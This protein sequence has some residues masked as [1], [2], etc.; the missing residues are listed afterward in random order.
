LTS[1]WQSHYLETLG[2]IPAPIAAMF[3]AD[4]DFGAA[5]TGLRESI[6]AERTEGLDVATKELLFVVLDVALDNLPG[7]QNHLNAAV[8]AGLTD[9]AL[10][11]ALMIVFAMCGIGAW[12]KTGSHLWTGRPSASG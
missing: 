3:D 6:Y 12:G 8:D 5:Y 9:D 10:K 1:D 11:E 4:E 7:A 2:N